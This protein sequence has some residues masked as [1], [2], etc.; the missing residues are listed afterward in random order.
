MDEPGMPA[1]RRVRVRVPSKVNL[2]LAVRGERDDGFH[3]LVSVM[4]TISIHDA[5]TVSIDGEHVASLHP[6]ARRFVCLRY[7]QQAGPGVPDLGLQQERTA[8]AWDRTALALLVVG[9]LTVRAGG[10]S[11]DLL[12]NAPGFLTV[13]VGAGLLWAGGR[14]YRRR[15]TDLRAGGSP[16]RPRLVVVTGVTTVAIS[17]VALVGILVG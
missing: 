14:H 3:E 1:P 10:P 17:V 5:V 8:L 6:T 12:R 9:A 2:F 16:V 15:A 7:S 4:Q 13:L 11:F